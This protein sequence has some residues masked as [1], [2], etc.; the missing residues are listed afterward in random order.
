MANRGDAR[1]PGST[2]GP[3]ENYA[4]HVGLAPAIGIVLESGGLTF[5][6]ANHQS[7]QGTKTVLD[8]NATQANPLG[9]SH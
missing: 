6:R 7:V 2:L 9:Q 3:N 8:K 4:Q 5:D 1:N